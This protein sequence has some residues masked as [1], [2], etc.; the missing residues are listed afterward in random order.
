MIKDD[1]S[2]WSGVHQPESFWFILSTSFR[3]ASRRS[4]AVLYLLT[5]DRVLVRFLT[6]SSFRGSYTWYSAKSPIE[7]G[8]FKMAG[9]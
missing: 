3:T 6:L 7:G 2:D 4:R 1:A 5:T 8:S 9:K